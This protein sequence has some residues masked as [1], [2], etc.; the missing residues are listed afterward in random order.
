MRLSK[1]RFSSHEG[2]F[3]GAD[4]IIRKSKVYTYETGTGHSVFAAIYDIVIIE[5]SKFVRVNCGPCSN[6]I[7]DWKPI[8][9]A[10]DSHFNL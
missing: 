1:D 4:K 6:L 7:S 9:Y 5:G 10:I 2:L 8:H 3:K